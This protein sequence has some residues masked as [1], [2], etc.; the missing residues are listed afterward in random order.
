MTEEA[1]EIAARVRVLRE[2]EGISEVSLAL[3]L[4]FDPGEYTQ[5]E[6]SAVTS[7]ICRMDFAPSPRRPAGKCF[8]R[9]PV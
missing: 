8:S 9:M 6:S 1:R 5:W 3:A 7:L 4:G 2:I